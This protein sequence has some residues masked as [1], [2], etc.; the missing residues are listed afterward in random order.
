LLDFALTPHETKHK[1]PHAVCT[2]GIASHWM[3]AEAGPIRAILHADWRFDAP[4][5]LNRACE[6][7]PF[8]VQSCQ[9]EAGRRWKLALPC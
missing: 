3:R 4:H 1:K 9:R 5:H 2:S 7:R 6:K 8:A